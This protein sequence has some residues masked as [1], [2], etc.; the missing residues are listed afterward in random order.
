M[1]AGETA[2]L[3]PGRQ[4]FPPKGDSWQRQFCPNYKGRPGPSHEGLMFVS[5]CLQL[6]QI[7]L[8]LGK[9]EPSVLVPLCFFSGVMQSF[10]VWFVKEFR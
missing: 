1:E 3:L 10:R 2:A 9:I 4:S 7:P 6:R 8:H 5:V